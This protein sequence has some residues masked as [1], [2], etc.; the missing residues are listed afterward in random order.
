MIQQSIFHKMFKSF[1]IITTISVISLA[2]IMNYFFNNYFIKQ[3][4]E[5]LLE[6]CDIIQKQ[7]DLANNSFLKLNF[8]D[9]LYNELSALEK[10]LQA[11]LWI[12]NKNGNLYIDSNSKNSPSIGMNVNYNELQSIFEGNTI[13]IQDYSNKYFNEPV[14]IIG[15]PLKNNGEVVFALL[16]HSPLPGIKKTSRDIFLVS[17]LIILI[18][19]IIF[20]SVIFTIGNKFKKELYHIIIILKKISKGSF[21][22]RIISNSK[23]EMG[24]LARHINYM[25][26]E[27]NSIEKSRKTFIT[28]ISHDLRSPLTSIAGYS[29]AILDHTIPCEDQDHYIKIIN[30][31]S[32]RLTELANSLISLT[33]FESFENLIKKPFDLNNL[34]LNTL[35]SFEN[36]IQAKNLSVDIHLNKC[37]NLALGASDQL[38]RVLYNLIDNA[39]KFSHNDGL[40]KIWI[41]SF[42]NQYIIHIK[43][44]GNYISPEQLN[45]IWD[46]FY[47]I[48]SSRGSN[49]NGYGLGLS[50]VREIIKNHNEQ[51]FVESSKENGT[52]FSFTLENIPNNFTNS[53]FK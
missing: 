10:Y 33:K 51:I 8:S 32:I 29:K 47:K 40:L 2:L 48:D 49:K 19:F 50:I 3:K 7:F 14:L 1:V 18:T 38:E 27:L 15:Y 13:K 35:D 26:H 37:P 42:K 34:L 52:V 24:E 5:I 39:I 9:Q 11:R 20:S 21:N 41:E 28:N 25:A 53:K 30:N 43:N 44:L 16:I 12:I 17:L 4:E 36:R 22:E 31:E 45:Q 46:R 23:D 6:Q